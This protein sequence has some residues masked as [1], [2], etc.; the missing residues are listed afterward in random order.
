VAQTFHGVIR[1]GEDVEDIGIRWHWLMHSL[2]G[3]VG[4]RVVYDVG[5]Q[6]L[7]YPPTWVDTHTEA[8]LVENAVFEFLRSRYR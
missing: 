2:I 3:L 6:V 5:L 7:E 8:D 1:D 4:P